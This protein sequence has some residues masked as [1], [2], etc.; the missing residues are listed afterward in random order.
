[1]MEKYYEMYRDVDTDKLMSWMSAPTWEGK[2]DG[3]LEIESDQ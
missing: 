2:D 1:M 3:N